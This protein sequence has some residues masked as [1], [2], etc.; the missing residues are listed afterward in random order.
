MKKRTV[1][2]V[3]YL[4]ESGPQVIQFSNPIRDTRLY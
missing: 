4:Q 2:Q 3:G 1:H